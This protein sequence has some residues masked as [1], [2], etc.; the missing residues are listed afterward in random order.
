MATDKDAPSLSTRSSLKCSSNSR[1]ASSKRPAVL[2][3]AG[4]LKS[5]GGRVVSN[6]LPF[7]LDR[8][9][10]STAVRS[11]GSR[12]RGEDSKRRCSVRLGLQADKGECSES[13]AE[14]IALTGI[15]AEEYWSAC[16]CLSWQ[17]VLILTLTVARKSA[18][19]P[20]L[21]LDTIVPWAAHT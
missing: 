16:L 14:I 21:L 10:L 7:S 6:L 8:R 2:I 1:C 17:V 20:L 11:L 18:L 15:R 5:Y 9:F 12:T 13:T 4:Q 3:T 19:I